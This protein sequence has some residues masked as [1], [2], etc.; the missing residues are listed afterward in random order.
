M[1]PLP[2]NP[3]LT[4]LP[5][6]LLKII[7]NHLPIQDQQLTAPRISK[8]W[9]AI[10][11]QI[12]GESIDINH[13]LNLS[14]KEFETVKKIYNT[15]NFISAIR[16][17]SLWC[18]IGHGSCAMFSSVFSAENAE[19]DR[20]TA[21][22]HH[23]GYNGCSGFFN[24]NWNPS[25]LKIT[26]EGNNWGDFRSRYA[27]GVDVLKFTYKDFPILKTISPRSWGGFSVE[28]RHLLSWQECSEE[29]IQPT[30][31]NKHI[32]DALTVQLKM[33]VN[34]LTHLNM[35]FLS[36][37]NL[38]NEVILECNSSGRIIQKL[39]PETTLAEDHFILRI[40][41]KRLPGD[42]PIPYIMWTA[43]DHSSSEEHQCRLTSVLRWCVYSSTTQSLGK[44]M[45]LKINILRN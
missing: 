27:I 1:L 14:G 35:I 9:R 38:E 31:M 15:T 42:F 39:P 10:A 6:D 33:Y 28:K 36:K 4:T 43:S 41:K 19:G 2:I 20:M 29:V 24:I 11:F 34:F 5:T 26:F 37:I 25:T 12:S 40:A 45:G 23:N 13:G 44:K 22:G 21:Q 8:I 7:Y 3:S 17:A 32:E 16:K 18:S 30:K